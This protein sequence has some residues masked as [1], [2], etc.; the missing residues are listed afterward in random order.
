MDSKYSTLVAVVYYLIKETETEL[1]KV[2]PDSETY[3][4][5]RGKLDAYKTVALQASRLTSEEM[6]DLIAKW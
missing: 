5:R 6:D 2:L 1:G 3:T 4:Y